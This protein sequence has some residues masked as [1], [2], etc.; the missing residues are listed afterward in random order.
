MRHLW[1]KCLAALPLP[2]LRREFLRRT[3][4]AAEPCVCRPCLNGKRPRPRGSVSG[5]AAGVRARTAG[6]MQRTGKKQTP[7]LRTGP[8]PYLKLPQSSCRDS[9]LVIA[10]VLAGGCIQ[11]ADTGAG[12]Q[13]KRHADR[14]SHRQLRQQPF[15]ITTTVAETTTTATPSPT[16]TATTT[17]PGLTPAGR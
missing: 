3:P 13:R 8:V 5:T 12:R 1:E 4:A 6:D 15:L 2:V 10:F 9:I 16:P 17:R 11:P 14:D 7:G